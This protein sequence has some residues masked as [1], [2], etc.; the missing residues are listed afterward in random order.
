M[1]LMV[2]SINI[3]FIIKIKRGRSY[4]K[5]KQMMCGLLLLCLLVTSMFVA[6]QNVKAATKTDWK[7]VYTKIIKEKYNPSQWDEYEN[8]CF[9]LIYINNDSIPELV[10]FSEYWKVIYTLKGS[11]YSE[12]DG[13]YGETFTYDKKSNMILMHHGRHVAVTDDVYKIKNGKFVSI[14]SGSYVSDDGV[15][16][17]DYSINGK[18]VSASTYKKKIKPYEK[19]CNLDVEK[20]KS[21]SYNEILKKLESSGSSKKNDL[22]SKYQDFVR[23]E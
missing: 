19:K 10:A 21:Y 2:V 14:W 4:E 1:D 17:R 9:K 11:E 13:G 18:D 22:K 23:Q 20:A 12:I 6:P 8:Y 15:H 7:K 3:I 5:M 16:C